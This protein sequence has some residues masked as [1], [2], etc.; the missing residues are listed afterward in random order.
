ME[1]P[2]RLEIADDGNANYLLTYASLDGKYA[3]DEWH[4][5][6]AGAYESATERFGIELGE[7]TSASR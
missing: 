7:W 6:L 1:V 2:F 5:T 4:E 3:T